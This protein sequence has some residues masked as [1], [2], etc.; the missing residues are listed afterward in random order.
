MQYLLLSLN[1]YLNTV[2]NVEIPN[3]HKRVFGARDKHVMVMKESEACDLI[4]M[5]TKS[6]GYL[7]NESV[8][9]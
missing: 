5:P 4:F 7:N 8:A 1:E 3:T 2:L 6:I 9:T